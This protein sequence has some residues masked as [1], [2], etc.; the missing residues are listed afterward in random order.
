MHGAAGRAVLYGENAAVIEAQRDR[1]GR[2]GEA[3][4]G[5]GRRAHPCDADRVTGDAFS[6]DGHYENQLKKNWRRKGGGAAASRGMLRPR[7]G[8]WCEAG[9]LKTSRAGR[10]NGDNRSS[11]VRLTRCRAIPASWIIPFFLNCSGSLQ[12]WEIMPLNPVGGGLPPVGD[13][14]VDRASPRRDRRHLRCRARM[15]E[16]CRPAPGLALGR[17]RAKALPAGPVDVPPVGVKLSERRRRRIHAGTRAFP[18][19][20]ST[21]CRKARS[22]GR[23]SRTSPGLPRSWPAARSS[24]RHPP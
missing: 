12:Y 2:H 24:P 9:R 5:P 8:A 19:R 13:P 22:R 6:R 20:N 21:C 16:S 4:F 3:P 7:C 15:I 23:P 17:R 11:A 14:D 1:E 18:G 10:N